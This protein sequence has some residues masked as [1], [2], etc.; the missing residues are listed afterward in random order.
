MSS[1]EGASPVPLSGEGVVRVWSIGDVS[2][3]VCVVGGKV[4]PE[5]FQSED[6]TVPVVSDPLGVPT[7]EEVNLGIKHITHCI[8]DL[9][10][11]AQ[12]QQQRE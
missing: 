3:C 7:V 1:S 9:L 12:S 4:T 8:Q 6:E 2:V 10:R 11:A 5:V